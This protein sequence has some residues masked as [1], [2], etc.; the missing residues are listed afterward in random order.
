MT[1]EFYPTTA[2][3]RAGW[4]V[5]ITTGASGYPFSDQ[6]YRMIR[7]LDAAEAERDKWHQDAV[8]QMHKYGQISDELLMLTAE[9][10]RFKEALQEAAEWIGTADI[11]SDL[12]KMRA[13]LSDP[14]G[15]RT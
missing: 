3:E 4:L 6:I 7:H 9:R 2:E 11:A 13:A 14:S 1:I 5:A 12:P 8:N 15:D 10:D